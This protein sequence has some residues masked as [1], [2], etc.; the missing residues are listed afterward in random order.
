MLQLLTCLL[1]KRPS[2]CLQTIPDCGKPYYHV[3]ILS[4]LT[5]RIAAHHLLALCQVFQ[6]V[7]QEGSIESLL[8]IQD[9]QIAVMESLE[10]SASRP[11]NPAQSW[12]SPFVQGRGRG[13]DSTASTMYRPRQ[14]AGPA[15]SVHITATAIGSAAVN[16]KCLAS[17]NLAPLFWPATSICTCTA[18]FSTF[19]SC[20]STS[21]GSNK[22]C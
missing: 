17:P 18:S 14:Q 10:P 13:C 4:S 2:S 11:I 19:R 15:S 12:P 9:Q 5:L 1:L 7:L 20:T 22:P 16:H 6:Q 21:P 8:A 3:H